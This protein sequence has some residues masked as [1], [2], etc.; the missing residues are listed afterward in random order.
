M[1]VRSLQLCSTLAVSLLQSTPA[2]RAA[3]SHPA[4]TD[5]G[6]TF[7]VGVLGNSGQNLFVNRRGELETIRRYDLDGNGYLDL[8]FNSTHD[9]YNAVPAT[10]VTAASGPAVNVAELGVEGS[11]IVVP[12]DLNRDG[13]T[14]LVFMPNRQNI[15]KDRSSITVAWGAADGWSTARLTRQLPVN[16]V[17]DL[18]VGDLNG[19]GW[20]DIL[21]LNSEGWL[22]GQPPGRIV[23]IYW[24]SQEG[25]FL[26]NYQDL[27]IP[28]ATALVTGGFGAQREFSAAVLS[29]TGV[30]HYL[31]GNAG[32]PGVHV[33][34]TVQL[35]ATAVAGGA[36]VKP[37]SLCAQPRSGP[38]GDLLWIGTN[39]AV[40]FRVGTT[41]QQ[42]DVKSVDAV[43]AT[44]LALGRL[45]DDAWPDLVLTNLKLV[46]PL[47]PTP[48]GGNS[49]TVLWGTAE[50]VSTAGSTALLVPNAIA[51]A[52][53]DLNA[54]GHG[55]LIVSVHQGKE[56]M[57]AS[58]RVYFGKG[59]RQLPASGLPV[60]TEGARGV[61]VARVTPQAPPAAVFAN[62]MHATLD[63]AVPVRLYWGSANGF[64]V[65]AKVDI[66]NLS[67][68]KSSASDL[69]GDGHV[70][71]ILIN[72]GDVGEETIARA[73]LAGVNIYWGGAEGSISGPG[74]TRFDAS[75]RQ[76]LRE[77]RLGSLNVA[78]LNADGFLDLI[79]GA[80]ES[81]VLETN[82]VIYYGSAA[83][84]RPENRKVSREGEIF[85]GTGHG[86]AGQGRNTVHRFDRTGRKLGVV[87]SGENA[88]GYPHGL[89]L[90][91]EGSLYVADPVA[92]EAAASPAK[93]VRR[94]TG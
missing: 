33:A 46:Y 29:T 62:S 93:F 81:S 40:L 10:V 68:Y 17:T 85:V 83:G 80:F 16:A 58:S 5:S 50:G 65:T 67:G 36:T 76:V 27:G 55:D 63:S 52:V 26:A 25:Y 9:T 56:S 89:H 24:G 8:L 20:A 3:D 48:T 19:D 23:R 14:D 78:D 86:P 57:K 70:D 90:D 71:L 13:F 60:A 72:G 51:T 31:A 84:L 12:H 35:P 77:T 91:A 61:A 75:R 34:R 87:G 39:S 53:G 43:P 41:G 38:A 69:N 88:F 64:S 74:P 7:S 49:V 21:S 45:D 2:I 15:Q 73:P 59:D 1:N 92:G 6:A 18:A 54:D 37:Q 28:Q 32:S 22:F 44:H 94:A 79:L 30:I 66:P 42:D 11:S 47:D 4:W 82:L